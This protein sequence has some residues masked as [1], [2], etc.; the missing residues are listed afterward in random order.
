MDL[1]NLTKIQNLRGCKPR[2]TR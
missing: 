1:S 2:C